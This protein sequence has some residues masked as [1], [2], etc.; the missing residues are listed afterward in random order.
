MLLSLALALVPAVPQG[1]LTVDAGRGPIEVTLPAGYDPAVPAPL[2]MLLHGYGSNGADQESYLR[3]QPFQDEYGFVYVTPDGTVDGLGN[4]Y[5]NATGA[6]C[7]FFGAGTDDSGY[8]LALIEAIEAVASIDARSIHIIGHSNGGF[9]SYRMACDHPDKIASIAS[10]AGATHLDPAD[11]GT[12]NPVHILQIHGTNDGTIA[13]G[14]GN[15]LGNFYPG[16]VETAQL[17]AD[18]SGCDPNTTVEQQA[19]NLDFSVPGP[20]SSITRYPSGCAAGGSVELWTIPGGS[21]VPNVTPAFRRGVLEHLL[22]R[23]QNGTD[24]ESYCA[25]AVA[26]STGLPGRISAAGSDVLV[27]NA[28]VL[29]AEDLPNQQFGYFLT[30][31]TEGLVT[32][33]GSQ[34]NLCLG[35]TILRFNDSVLNTGALGSFTLD[36]DLTS[37]P[38]SPPASAVTG[39]TWSFQAWFRDANP[40]ATSNFTDGVRLVIR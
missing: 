7:N 37:L 3:F 5:W 16:A 35:G 29:V 39:E 14:G 6:C 2:V 12:G 10:L 13:F 26:N 17:W 11:C 22:A 32:P 31:Q 38:S 1:T 36:V 19:L 9:M 25:P 24:G 15:I 18:K 8:L 40:G 28:L 23:P 30:S 21:H 33:A 27:D 4:R 34:G 20:E